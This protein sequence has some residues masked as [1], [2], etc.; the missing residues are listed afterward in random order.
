MSE[1]TLG[2]IGGG[3]L[4]SMLAIAA[5][6]L[7]DKLGTYEGLFDISDTHSGGKREM[8][9]KLKPEGRSLGLTQADLGR[10]VRQAYYGEEIQRIQRE[11]DEVKVML[12]K[13]KGKFETLEKCPGPS[14]QIPAKN[15]F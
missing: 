6:K 7:K 10:Q 12:D 9:I 4:G 5:K 14:F 2:I 1:I 3:Q 15:V 13:L 11:R 8:K